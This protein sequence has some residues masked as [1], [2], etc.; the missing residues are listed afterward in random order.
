MQFSDLCRVHDDLG[1]EIVLFEG[2]DRDVVT[3]QG[4]CKKLDVS[5]L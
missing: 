4:L 3:F 2:I 5:S 1:N